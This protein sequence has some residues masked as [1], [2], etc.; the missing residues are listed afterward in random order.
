MAIFFVSA[1]WN[2]VSNIY[3]L[4]TVFYAVPLVKTSFPPPITPPL[5]PPLS[6]IPVLLFTRDSR[7]LMVE[8]RAF[9]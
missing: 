9:I 8:V 4:Q 2:F 5:F 6:P 7:V 3:V 1:G